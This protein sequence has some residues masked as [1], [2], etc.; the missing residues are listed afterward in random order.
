MTD[1]LSASA[2]LAAGLIV[3]FMF[4]YGM[5]GR[6]TKTDTVRADLEAKR[7]AL[8]ARLREDPSDKRLELE[9][10]EVLKKLD[11]VAP[12]PPAAGAAEGRGATQTNNAT[13]KG[14][15]WGAGSVAVLAAI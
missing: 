14:F 9:A 5:K 1:W 15:A 12:P 8:L 13:I 10:A 7:D 6:Q 11:S 3:G 2:M 4:L